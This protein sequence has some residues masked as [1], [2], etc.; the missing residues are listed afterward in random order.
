MIQ[1]SPN[2]RQAQLVI[3]LH[4]T[5][6]LECF[7]K[8]WNRPDIKISFASIMPGVMWCPNQQDLV[9]QVNLLR[10]SDV[11]LTPGS[12][13]V[14]EAAIF[15]TPTIVPTYSDL[16]PDHAAAQIGRW[17]LARHYKPLVEK[18]W[19]SVTRSYQETK[20]A[21]EEAFANP[22]QY[23]AGRKSIV[24]QYVYYPDGHSSQRVAE[25]IANVARTV[26]PGKPRGL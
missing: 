16:Q 10:H 4:P 13:W 5:S 6:R 25:W 24:E 1:E 2:L 20:K 7:W 17:T 15:D 11:I 9:E 21:L 23:A 18:H 26:T 19:V 8:Y 12:S 14:L 22:Q 3:R